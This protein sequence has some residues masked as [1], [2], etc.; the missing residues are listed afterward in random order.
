VNMSE[1]ESEKKEMNM[2]RLTSSEIISEET[3]V[4]W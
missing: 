1:S 2:K 4:S 3:N